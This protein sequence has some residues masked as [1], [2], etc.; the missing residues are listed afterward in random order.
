[1]GQCARWVRF[2]H[3]G[4]GREWGGRRWGSVVR[5]VGFGHEGDRRGSKPHIVISGVCRIQW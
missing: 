3:E 4:W 2:G 5:W 1:M